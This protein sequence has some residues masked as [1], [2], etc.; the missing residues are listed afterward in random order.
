[1]LYNLKN[2]GY[3]G[4]LQY[5]CKLYFHLFELHSDRKRY[6]F[7]TF[8][9]LKAFS[10]L[11]VLLQKG[12]L[13][14]CFVANVQCTCASHMSPPPGPLYKQLLQVPFSVSLLIDLNPQVRIFHLHNA[15]VLYERSISHTAY[16]VCF[17]ITDTMVT[18]SKGGGWGNMNLKGCNKREKLISI[19]SKLTHI[20]FFKFS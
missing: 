1:M 17:Y 2:Y 9:T 11:C 3:V 18:I 14:T 5:F 19:P 12:P 4:K 6:T 7:Q 15:C 16:P 20:H 8:L 13:F 10:A